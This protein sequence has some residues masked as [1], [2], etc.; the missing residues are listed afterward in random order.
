[1]VNVNVVRIMLEKPLK[2]LRR[3][4]QNTI[5]H[6]Q[7]LQCRSNNQIT[8]SLEA[9]FIGFMKPFLNDQTSFDR[10]T[11]FRNDIT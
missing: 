3:N 8:K 6:N 5:K 1:M 11:P 7:N 9:L 4:G 10:L 2:I